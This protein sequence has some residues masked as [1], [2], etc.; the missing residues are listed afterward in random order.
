MTDETE[1]MCVAVKPDG[2]VGCVLPPAHKGRHKWAD[3][4]E[5]AAD[6]E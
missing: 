2:T 6:D 5:Q 1:G 3:A 4:P